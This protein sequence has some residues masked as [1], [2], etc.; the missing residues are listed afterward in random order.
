MFIRIYLFT[1]I[2]IQSI[3]NSTWRPIYG[4]TCQKW[5][6]FYLFK[7][8]AFLFEHTFYGNLNIDGISFY[9]FLPKAKL[10]AF[11]QKQK[12]KAKI[13]FPF[14]IIDR[15]IQIKTIQ[16]AFISSIEDITKLHFTFFISGNQFILS[17]PFYLIHIKISISFTYK[18]FEQELLS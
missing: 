14:Q 4:K 16:M 10:W 6:S 12:I 9:Q 8:S 2:R 5:C 18:H 17:Y 13:T 7:R 11:N 15:F 1:H 3:I